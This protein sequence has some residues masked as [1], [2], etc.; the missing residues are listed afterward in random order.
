MSPVLQAPRFWSRPPGW[1]TRLLGPL[2]D[3]Y[4]RRVVA[5]MKLP[6]LR[7]A[8]PVVCIGNFT[9]GG[10]GKTPLALAVAD[11]LREVGYN[12]AFLT[13]GYGGSAKGPLRVA[14]GAR[15]GRTGRAAD[16][17][18]HHLWRRSMPAEHG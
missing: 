11:V 14:P 18:A 4:G 6:G 12:P 3:A 13:R 1:L 8:V 5:R 7:A 2:G 15:G 17:P 9:L 10:A 16:Q